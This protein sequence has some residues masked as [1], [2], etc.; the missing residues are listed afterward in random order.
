MNLLLFVV[1]ALAAVSAPRA[2]TALPSEGRV[3]AALEGALL[4][5]AGTAALAALA[6]PLADAVSLATPTVRMAAGAVLAA[7]GIA[8]MVMALPRPEPRLA[9]RRAA[10]MP[11]AFPTLFT[12]ALGILAVSGSLDHS[13]GVAI[14]VLA[15][16]LATVPVLAIAMPR[17]PARVVRGVAA[18]VGAL[19]TVAGIGLVFDGI[20]DI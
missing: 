14:A 2:L 7:Q 3:R 18:L 9:G 13:I 6:D 15:V 19:L 11:V 5:L 17:P 16:A 10:L 4:T 12:P 20:F 1:A 8:A